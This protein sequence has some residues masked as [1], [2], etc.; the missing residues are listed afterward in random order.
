VKIKANAETQRARRFAE[1]EEVDSR[2]LKVERSE[3][4]S[5]GRLGVGER[6]IRTL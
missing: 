2:Q 3:E 1:S 4:E 5:G 6:K